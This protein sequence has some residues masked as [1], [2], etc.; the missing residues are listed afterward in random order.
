VLLGEP[1]LGKSTALWQY[2]GGVEAGAARTGTAILW[3][4]LNA[5][6][7]EE[8]LIRAVFEDSRFTAWAAGDRVLHLFLD[9]LDECL[10]RIDTLTC[11]LSEELARFPIS[12]LR[13]RLAC[14]TAVWPALLEHRLR[15]LWGDASVGVYE[16]TPLR[17]RD[18]AE[19]AQRSRIDADALLAEIDRREASPL[20]S[21]PVTLLFLLRAF[22]RGEGWPRTQV[23]LYLRGCEQLCTESSESRR[24]ARRMGQISPRQRMAVASRVAAVSL[25]CASPVLWTGG[26]AGD[27]PEGYLP[28]EDLLGGTE[29]VD[30]NPVEVTEATVREVLDTGLFS[31]RG[32]ERIGFSHQTYAEFLAAD[33]LVRRGL[34]P[35]QILSLILHPGG[36]G[37]VVPQLQEAAAW[38]AALVPAV[39]EHILRTDPQV[40]LRSDVATMSAQTREALVGSLLQLF[41]EGALID[42]DWGERASYRKLAHSGLAEQLRPYISDRAKNIIV[43]RVAINIA[44]ACHLRDLQHILA[45]VALDR[46]DKEHVR[47]QAVVAVMRMGDRDARVQ[48]KPLLTPDA[49]DD[50][51]DELK[52][53]ALLALWREDLPVEELFPALTPAKRRS[54]VGLYDRFIRDALIDRLRPEDLPALL[55]WAVDQPASPEPECS[56]RLVDSLLEMAWHRIEDDG[57]LPPYAAIS[58]RRLQHHLPIPAVDRSA[59]AAKRH[60]LAEAVGTVLRQEGID[61][62]ALVY[63]QTPLVRPD[64]LPWVIER[65]RAAPD[66]ECAGFWVRVVQAVYRPALDHVEALLQAMGTCAPLEEAFRPLFAPV[67][68]DSPEAEHL[69]QQYQQH[70]AAMAQVQ[71]RQTVLTPPPHQRVAILLGR[72]EAGN[73]DAW[74]QLNLELTLEPTSTHY[75]LDMEADVTTMPGWAAADEPTRLRIIRVAREYLVEMSSHVEDWLGSDRYDRR[76]LAAYRAL[77]LLAREDPATLETLGPDLWRKWATACVAYPSAIGIPGEEVDQLMVAQVYRHAPQEVIR[78]LLV[79]LDRENQTNS[80][81]FMHRK[82]ELCWDATLAEALTVKARDPGLKPACMGSL[83][84]SLLMHGAPQGVELAVSLVPVPVSAEGDTRTRAVTAAAL[85]FSFM[86]EEAW[87]RIWPTMQVDSAFG[88]E[89]MTEVAQRHDQGFAA[90]LA[91]RLSERQIAD[92]FLW[93]TQHFPPAEDPQHGE[94]YWVGPRERVVHFRDAVFRQ[95]QHRGTVTAREMVENLATALPALPWLRWAA[96]ETRA[97]TLRHTWIPPPP[98]V[99]LRLGR[100]REL[101]LVESGEQLLEVIIESLRRLQEELQGETPAAPDLWNRLEGGALRPKS[102]NE[103]SDYLVR[104]LRRDVQGRGIIAN[105]EVEI[106]RGEGEAEG[107]RTDIHIDALAA[108]PRPNEYD[109]IS[110]IIEAKGCWNRKVNEDMEGQLRDRYLRDNRCRHGIYLVGWFVCDQW[111]RKDDRRGRTPR[112]TATEA[113]SHFDAQARALSGSVQIRAVVLNAALR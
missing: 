9:S 95:L 91:Q 20:A 113:Q 35:R 34:A 70:V 47:E 10:L 92:L 107:E 8:R 112:M 1:G 31:A 105:R 71:Q 68:L 67:A 94:G 64:D 81:L 29:D 18:V 3:K 55:R 7:S 108:G 102:E 56:Q 36:D 77:L 76:D 27:V 88:E 99:L 14:R 33:Y 52:G 41:D 12:R 45:D 80:T 25:F 65:V 104:H 93:L 54:F 38:L 87:S 26:T 79:L 37:R 22:Q 62:I 42:S 82:L 75:G 48:L 17:R 16:L 84:E 106:R 72:A 86:P 32:L 78:A 23:D 89:V 97:I 5:Y 24:A 57:I 61:P 83:L 73:L 11:L 21:R 44:N 2:R 50:S 110:V 13:L 51:Q 100:D 19:G 69:R 96:V 15:E 63:S 66:A 58:A 90:S 103:F 30:G 60:R 46:T 40:L 53:A 4:D 85:L 74:W 28:L 101:R 111:D 6:Q 49:S 43:R 98:Q 59:D 39:R 109:R